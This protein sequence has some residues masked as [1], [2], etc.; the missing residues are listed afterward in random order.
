M[1]VGRTQLATSWAGLSRAAH[2]AFPS[3]AC[4]RGCRAQRGGRGFFVTQRQ[5]PSPGFADW[6]PLSH[7]LPQAGEGKKERAAL[8]AAY[9]LL[10]SAPSIMPTAFSTP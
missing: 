7:P 6:R 4:G 5:A 9:A 2:S 3:P 8:R 10:A 1:V